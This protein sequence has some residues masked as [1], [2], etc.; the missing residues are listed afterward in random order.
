MRR[1]FDCGTYST[2]VLNCLSCSFQICLLRT[3]DFSNVT[4][5]ETCFNLM[6]TTLVQNLPLG[7]LLLPRKF[8]SFGE[9][10]LNFRNLD[11]KVKVKAA[12]HLLL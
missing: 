2:V 5:A 11:S 1:L 7:H 12:V 3:L 9:K 4:E 6:V 8:F 10:E